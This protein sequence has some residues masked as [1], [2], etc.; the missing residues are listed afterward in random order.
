MVENIHYI[1][2]Y[3][4]T[5]VNTVY[6]T[7]LQ[8][9]FRFIVLVFG[10]R[11]KNLKITRCTRSRVAVAHYIIGIY[12]RIRMQRCQNLKAIG[13]ELSEIDDFQQIYIYICIYIDLQS[14]ASFL[15]HYITW[16]NT[17]F[18]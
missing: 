7:N 13:E 12:A 9:I 3:I 1:N 5:Y 11:G 18:V 16:S 17:N 8:K 15:N 6:K 14:I 4:C 10:G 2:I